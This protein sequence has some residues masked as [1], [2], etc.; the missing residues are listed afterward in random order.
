MIDSDS[1]NRNSDEKIR[2]MVDFI[3]QM[4]AASPSDSRTAMLGSHEL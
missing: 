3:E 1:D 4:V 2:L